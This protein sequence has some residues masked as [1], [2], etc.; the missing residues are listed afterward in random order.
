MNEPLVSAVIITYNQE[1]YIEQTI[2]C[3]LAQKVDFDYEIVIGEDCS[4][5]RTRE[6]CLQYQKKYP[7]II[8][9]ITSNSN[10]GLMEN[11]FRTVSASRGKYFAACGGDD[12]WH[13]YEK[14]SKQ[15][16]IMKNTP[17]IGMVHSDE[18]VLYDDTGILLKCF[19]EKSKL[20]YNNQSDN[21][22]DLLFAGRYKIVAS[23]AMYRTS[24][25]HDHFNLKELKINNVII[26]DMPLFIHIAAHSRVHYIHESLVTRRVVN[27]SITRQGYENEIKLWESVYSCYLYLFKK[28]EMK[29]KDRSINF[30]TIYSLLNRLMFHSAF[31][32]KKIDAARLYYRNIRS[33][34]GKE[35]V[36][37]TDTMKYY[38]TYLP[39]GTLYYKLF[40]DLYRKFRFLLTGKPT[41]GVM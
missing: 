18:N 33:L 39:F 3:A 5:D 8:R 35:H 21:P 30:K 27:G 4:T 13:D 2:E 29:I 10:V 11:F 23:S 41:R 19:N 34:A 20:T 26:E 7:N 9:V 37:T 16:K 32:A 1:K 38:I 36:K 22:L 17:E 6:I 15:I 28:Y 12:Y 14:I 24:L 40:L 31:S 25:F